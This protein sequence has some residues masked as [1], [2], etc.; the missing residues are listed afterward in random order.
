MVNKLFLTYYCLFAKE[1]NLIVFGIVKDIVAFPVTLFTGAE[2]PKVEEKARSFLYSTARAVIACGIVWALYKAQHS[3]PIRKFT[4]PT[5]LFTIDLSRLSFSLEPI[6][7]LIHLYF[8]RNAFNFIPSAISKWNA[9]A[10]LTGEEFVNGTYLAEVAIKIWKYLSQVFLQRKMVGPLLFFSASYHWTHLTIDALKHLMGISALKIPET[11]LGISM[12]L[13]GFGSYQL[14]VYSVER[15]FYRGAPTNLAFYGLVHVIF[16]L[17]WLS[18]YEK[19]QG[20][21]AEKE[22]YLYRATERLAPSLAWVATG[23]QKG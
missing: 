16:G 19:Y 5:T 20:S 3:E 10:S 22:T 8:L 11:R 17:G 4:L 2:Y 15:W 1:N 9:G 18:L 21:Q 12:F 23:G 7:C 6:S 14:Y 13:T